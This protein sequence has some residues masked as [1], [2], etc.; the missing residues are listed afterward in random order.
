MDPAPEF[1]EALLKELNFFTKPDEQ[2]LDCLASRIHNLQNISG[3]YDKADYTCYA[4]IVIKALDDLRATNPWL[5]IPKDLIDKAA[6]IKN[7]F[8][9]EKEW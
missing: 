8:P 4:L 7:L 2:T 6:K 1:T 9:V 5:S 3:Y